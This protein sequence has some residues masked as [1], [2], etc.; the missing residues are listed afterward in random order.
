MGF[1]LAAATP[2]RTSPEP[3]TGSGYSSNFS[4]SGPPYS[5]TMIAF[6]IHLQVRQT[7][8]DEPLDEENHDWLCND[9]STAIPRPPFGSTE[10][11][12][13]SREIS[14]HWPLSSS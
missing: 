12:F 5:W 8:I 13:D 6:I 7:S 2:T 14:L 1:T 3:G 10:A 4:T 11:F 9:A